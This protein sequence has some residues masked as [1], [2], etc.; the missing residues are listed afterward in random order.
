MNASKTI[1]RITTTSHK[2]NTTMP[3]MP[4]PATVLALATAIS[5][6]RS[7]HG[8]QLPTAA[9]LIRRVFTGGRQCQAPADPGGGSITAGGMTVTGRRAAPAPCRG[10]D[11]RTH[12]VLTGTRDIAG[13]RAGGTPEAG[14]AR[15]GQ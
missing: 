5:Y 14:D 3:G 2:K 4:Y 10:Q 15:P 11:D 9:H 6:S 7:S 12:L 1:A 8:H 13:G